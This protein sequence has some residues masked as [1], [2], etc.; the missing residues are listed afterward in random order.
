[1]T[2]KNYKKLENL[3]QHLEFGFDEMKSF[4]QSVMKG[5]DENDKVS[6]EKNFMILT[7]F[8]V[9]KAEESG[10]LFLKWVCK[11]GMKYLKNPKYESIIVK[12]M[13]KF[14]HCDGAMRTHK[15][16][17]T[18]IEVIKEKTTFDENFNV[19]FSRFIQEYTFE[20][21][22]LEDLVSFLKK[23]IIDT[24][25]IQFY[26]L[27]F[28]IVEAGHRTP[29][30][31]EANK[32]LEFTI[33]R[34]LQNEGNPWN[35]DL[36]EDSM[37]CA[38]ALTMI[39]NFLADSEELANDFLGLCDR[40]INLKIEN[41]KYEDWKY[42]TVGIR[43]FTYFFEGWIEF[44]LPKLESW[45]N[46]ILSKIDHENDFVKC[47][48]MQ[49][50]GICIHE[51]VS[52]ADE[53]IY[54]YQDKFFEFISPLIH[55]PKSAVNLLAVK[56]F[57]NLF[58]ITTEFK[59]VHMKNMFNIHISI[60]KTQ[61]DLMPT[62]AHS[63]PM[64]FSILKN[65]QTYFMFFVGVHYAE[66]GSIVYSIFKSTKFDELKLKSICL[67]IL[68]IL[69]TRNEF[70]IGPRDFLLGEAVKIYI[71]NTGNNQIEELISSTVSFY[72]EFFGEEYSSIVDYLTLDLERVKHFKQLGTIRES[73]NSFDF[74]FN[75]K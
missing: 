42:I 28:S 8:D 55:H 48:V 33:E 60:M 26:T 6:I 30:T 72:K 68:S 75:F 2:E 19:F 4:Y 41:K 71:E 53:E 61:R 32:I 56:F 9:E 64:L 11:M 24:G 17:N 59:S 66:I 18:L 3:F 13:F 16:M 73:K 47:A 14:Y 52:N 57:D 35:L 34:M 45:I 22:T 69:D 31:E 49:S 51:I 50:I 20:E 70:S 12:F 54:D 15:H 65:F 27:Y 46:L 5:F 38:E 23:K 36:F 58:D 40:Y 43:S 29:P 74:H 39:A 1:L 37:E 25:N 67:L 10:D 63:E 62:N 7:L 44:I 21:E